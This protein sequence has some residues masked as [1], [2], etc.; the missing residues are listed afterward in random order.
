MKGR[1]RNVNVITIAIDGPSGAGK[2]SIA[3]RLADELHYLYVDTG[4]LYRAI[5]LYMLRAGVDCNDETA[6]T[7][8]LGEITLIQTWERGHS[9]V[10]L[11][12]ED[13][14]EA[15]RTPE[16]SMAASHVSAH[17][18]VR[19]FLLELQRSF[20]KTQNVIM[21]GRDIGTVILPNA[22]VKVFLTASPEE[23]ARRRHLELLEKGQEITLSEV[24]SD[25][26]ERDHNDS[27]R[28]IAP[29]KQA[30]DAVLCDTTGLDFA[31]SVAALRAIIQKSC[32]L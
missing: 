7:P 26:I 28:A 20:A 8:L 22:T 25:V 24:L 31:E 18:S 29:L 6:L 16:A 21:D 10:F 15:I 9:T 5:G 2:S 4:A 12:G 27:T 3:K 17:K 30:P 14:S 32:N 11:N 13:V 1:E 19:Q 23:R